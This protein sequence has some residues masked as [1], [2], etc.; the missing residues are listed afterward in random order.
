MIPNKL[1]NGLYKFRIFVSFIY[2]FHQSFPFPCFSKRFHFIVNKQFKYKNL[3][4]END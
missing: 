1:F 3:S 2:I 4:L